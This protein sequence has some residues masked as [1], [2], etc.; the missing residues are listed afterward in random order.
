MEKISNSSKNIRNVE[1]LNLAPM[2]PKDAN[3]SVSKEREKK[4]ASKALK[5]F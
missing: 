4:I 1:P 5:G 2:T 3:N